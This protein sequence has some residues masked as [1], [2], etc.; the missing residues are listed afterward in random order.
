MST[1]IEELCSGITCV[2]D[3]KLFRDDDEDDLTA[4]INREIN[5]GAR[6]KAVLLGSPLICLK[7]GYALMHV[8]TLRESAPRRCFG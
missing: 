4:L 8:L 2:H 7:P 1:K 6:Y 5:V 3:Q